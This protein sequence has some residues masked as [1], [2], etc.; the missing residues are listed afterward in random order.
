MQEGLRPDQTIAGYRLLRPLGQGAGGAVF[1]AED[2]ATGAHVAL[3]L[4]NLQVGDDAAAAR[5]AFFRSADIARQLVHPDIV[6]L[7][8]AGVEGA[9]G[10]WAMEP[11]PGSDLS[12]YTQASRLLPETLVLQLSQRVALALAY[13]H[14]LGVVHRDLKPANVLFDLPSQTVKLADFGLARAADGVQTGTGMVLGSPAYMAPEQLAGGVPTPRSDFYALG[15]MLFQLLT[16]RLPNE[17]NSMGELLRQVASEPAPDLRQLRP[18]LP[19]EVAAL[20]AR[21]L[22]KRPAERPADGDAL[23]REIGAA[24]RTLPL[25]GAKSR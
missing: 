4:M 13:A 14:H 18:E 25:A 21:L 3:K 22:A 16:G 11:V 24:A 7:H 17:G 6:A 9:L 20:V 10:W 5:D 19:A 1:L 23:A 12:R 15:A 8:A 2:T